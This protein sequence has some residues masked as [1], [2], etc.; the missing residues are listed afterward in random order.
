M[1]RAQESYLETV[2]IGGFQDLC[3][4]KLTAYAVSDYPVKM[5][6]AKREKTADGVTHGSNQSEN[7]KHLHY[8]QLQLLPP[9]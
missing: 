3:F 9:G 8:D 2:M 1:L 7:S 4:P 5:G 6:R